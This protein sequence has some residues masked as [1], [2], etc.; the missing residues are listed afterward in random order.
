LTPYL[1]KFGIS[2]MLENRAKWLVSNNSYLPNLFS[3]AVGMILKFWNS[4]K[5]NVI[6]TKLLHSCI[7]LVFYTSEYLKEME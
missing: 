1:L 2:L 5:E 6:I 3:L 7:H 4:T